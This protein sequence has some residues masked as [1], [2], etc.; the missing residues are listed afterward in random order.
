[1]SWHLNIYLL[2]LAQVSGIIEG[3]NVMAT[4]RG[5]RKVVIQFVQIGNNKEVT[6]FLR[7]LDD[8][9]NGTYGVRVAQ[10]I[11]RSCAIHVTHCIYLRIS[12]I[13]RLP[14]NK[15]DS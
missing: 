15:L 7:Q 11:C 13:P 2:P 6:E 3:E 4:N 8:D 14:G 9:L 1:M 5:L 12:L 10:L